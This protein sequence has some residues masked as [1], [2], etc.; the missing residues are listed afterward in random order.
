MCQ[1]DKHVIF[2]CI[3]P[4]HCKDQD[5]VQCKF[6]KWTVDMACERLIDEYKLI[7]PGSWPAKPEAKQ[8]VEAVLRR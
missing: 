3:G 1:P 7:W 4:K 6:C 8:L 2:Y 5:Y